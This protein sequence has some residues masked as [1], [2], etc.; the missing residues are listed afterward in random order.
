M[1]DKFG[2]KTEEMIAAA[3]KGTAQ[4]RLVQIGLKNT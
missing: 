1:T 2:G 4:I 3:D